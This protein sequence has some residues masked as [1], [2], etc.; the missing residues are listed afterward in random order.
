MLKWLKKRWVRKFLLYSFL[1]FLAYAFY[2]NYVIVNRFESRR[3]NLPSRIYSDSLPLYNN[4]AITTS[5]LKDRLYHLNY[6]PVSQKPKHHGEVWQNGDQYSIYLHS[7]KYPHED[8]EGGRVSFRITNNKIS[9]LKA[10]FKN[11]NSDIVRLEPEVI[12]SIFDE[13]MED[14]TFVPLAEIPRSLTQAVIL[15][16]DERYYSHYGID[17]IGIARALFKNIISVRFAQGGSTLTQQMVKNFFLTHERTLVRKVNEALMALIIEMRYD[18]DDILEVYLNEIYFGQRGN[19][20][21]TGVQEASRFYF[22]KNVSQLTH[23]E[24]ALLAAVIR[25]P[26]LYSPFIKP[27]N[28]LNRRNLILKRLVDND[29]ITKKEYNKALARSLPVKKKRKNKSRA[30]YFVDFVKYQ[31]KENYSNEILYSEGFRI[32]TTLDAYAQRVAEASV[33]KWLT[34]LESTRSYLKKNASKGKT[35][36]GSLISIHPKTGYIRAYVGG[37]NFGKSQFDIIR[38]AKRQPG[39][40]FKPFVYLTALDPRMVDEPYTLSTLL[41]DNPISIKS[42]EGKYKPRNYDKKFHGFVRLREAL[43]KSYNVAT[44]WLGQ[45]IG[46]Q[47]IVNTAIKAGLND[48]IKPYPSMVLGPFEVTPLEM[49]SAY[50]V[51]PNNGTRTIPLSIRRVVKADGNVLEKKSFEMEKVFS[52]DVIYLMNKLMQ[53]VFDQGTATSARALGFTKLAAGKTGTTSDYRDAWFAGYTPDLLSLSWVGYKDNDK[54]N[55]SGASGALPIWTNYMKQVTLAK[56]YTDFTPAEN[57]VIVPIDKTSGKLYR[58]R[59][60]E[61]LE[62]YFIEGTEPKEDCR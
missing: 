25:S 35:L 54:T 44:V 26:G 59:C 12:T 4:K 33:T 20:S 49:I 58:R 2:L 14:R 60:D 56:T 50:S 38:L 3:W 43:E 46:L 42:S 17:P 22:S 40:T 6:R 8:F 62:E 19:A 48:R 39:S 55:L 27:K 16:E 47:K 28:G 53:G 61:E 36:E 45:Q 13:K 1:A 52:S 57:I 9:H 10:H 18:K 21:I 37:R 51:F 23:D 31:L 34:H 7:F 24:A 30:P 15:I 5:E 41:D 29:V 32:F 11:K